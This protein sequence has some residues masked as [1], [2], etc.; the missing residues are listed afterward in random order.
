MSQRIS[1][2]RFLTLAGAA[3]FT[4]A[5]SPGELL[6]QYRYLSPVSVP[7]PLADYP[8]RDWERIY[9]DIFRH[10]KTFVFMCYPNHTHN[11]L[12]NAFAKNNVV[13]RIEPTYG[14]G[15]ATDLY[16]N[17]ASH[18]WDPRCCQKGLVLA[19]RFYG[20]RRVNG[21]FLRK[22]FKDW[23]DQGFP[24]DPNSG[25]APKELMHRGWDSWERVPYEVAF[26]Y[27]TK[28]LYNIAKTYS[29]EQGKQYLL[30]QGYDPDMVEQ[31]GGAGRRVVKFRGGMAIH[32]R[33]LT[34]C[35]PLTAK[36][37][38]SSTA[39]VRSVPEEEAKG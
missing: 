25:A 11:R 21:A 34:A 15:K 30:A 39:L 27:H 18:R 28:A 8:N 3:G 35:W 31:V 29:G 24:R 12:L 22:G 17:K 32:A 36:E 9:R 13:V 38:P 23:V 7:N 26:Q 37:S 16:G 33:L 5:L 19:R 1:R 4:M 20:D 10:D 6:A 2:R 14:Y